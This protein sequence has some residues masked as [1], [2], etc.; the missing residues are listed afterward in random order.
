MTQCVEIKVF[1]LSKT[2]SARLGG[3]LEA[4]VTEAV[5]D[6]SAEF[7][8]RLSKDAEKLSRANT[9]ATEGALPFEVEF[10]KTNNA[11]FS[12]FST[13]VTLD[14]NTTFYRVGVTANGHGLQFDRLVVTGR[15]DKWQLELRRSPNH[16]VELASQH[17]T[18]E[19]DFG[20]F[21]MA[22]TWLDG[23]W[24]QGMYEGTYPY[25]EALFPGDPVPVYFPLIDYGG[26]CDETP[27]I[28]GSENTGVKAV[29]IE[30][31]RPLISFPYLLRQGFCL[32]GWTLE[33]VIFDA[34]W[35]KSLWLY[36]LRPDYYIAGTRGG[37]ITGRGFTRYDVNASTSGQGLLYYEE[38][39]QG[40]A[41]YTIIHHI[42]ITAYKLLGVV[43]NQGIALKYRFRMKG[44]FHNDRALF[45][46]SNI[47]IREVVQISS[48]PT[49]WERT[50]EILST[51]YLNTYFDPGDTIY[52]DFDQTVTLKPGMAAIIDFSE[53]PS[54]DFY[55]ES[56]LYFE[57]RPASK[58]LMTDDIVTISD[59]LSDDN[60]ILDWTKAFCQLTDSRIE[61]DFDTK[62]VTLHPNKRADLHGTVIPPFLKEEESAVDIS[63]LIVRSSIRSKPIRPNLKRYTRLEFANSGDAYISSLNL[64]SPAHSRTITNGEDYPDEI[65][66]FQNPVIEPTLEGQ[67][68]AL[69][70]GA[71]GR[72]QSPYLPRLWDNTNGE[73]SFEIG[74]RILFGFGEVRQINPQPF[75][76]AIDLHA[77]FFF[78]E[79]P[80]VADTG[81]KKYFGYATQLRTWELDPTPTIDGNVVFG[82]EQNDLFVNFWLGLTQNE[83]DGT[84]LDLLLMMKMK[85]YVGYDFRSLYFFYY[86][87]IPLR[88]P[89]TSI[90][91]FQTCSD[92]PT[93]VTFFVPPADTECC[94]LPCG[95]QFTTCEYYQDFGVYMRQAT[96]DLLK[97]DSFMVDGI[98]LLTAPVSFGYVNMVDVG[99][100]PFCTNLVDT[101]NSIAAP[102]FSFGI[103]TR[104]HPNRGA[105]F[106][107]CKRLACVPFRIVIT[108]SGAECYLYTQDEQKQKYFSGSWAALGYAPDT[109]TEP[110]DCVTVTEY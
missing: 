21:Q 22:E 75:N 20:T 100:Y 77:S 98:E 2:T 94:D 62:T 37:W 67:P 54:V 61:T 12:E 57:C 49:E 39:V 16:W 53:L 10:T 69:A 8:L 28:Q 43:N 96:L 106:F 27:P 81:L 24:P 83:R 25:T 71:S 110:I 9:I 50:G 60:T 44:R 18:N 6:L 93:P 66:S 65:D 7:S 4:P 46:D 97:V 90:R 109:Y 108:L 107:T 31:Y 45:F 42:G 30:D 32:F 86:N 41:S 38:A 91:D 82:S 56:G 103:S 88:V 68:T 58:C 36:A 34:D 74:P 19:V 76:T 95:C 99:G 51:E 73:R 52:I 1:G 87:G 101:L 3:T 80:N 40:L 48:S 15:T 26:W 102:Y 35:V 33:G 72:H 63:E 79:P 11:I 5:L 55:A 85:D 70:S 29:G 13:P 14:S 78:N 105:R 64:T 59:C 92:M 47:Y 23:N 17:K 84:E 89:M 104:I